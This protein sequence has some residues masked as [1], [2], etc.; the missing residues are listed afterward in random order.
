MESKDKEI[1]SHK[2]AGNGHLVFM[3]EEN[4]FGWVAEML[5]HERDSSNLMSQ[6]TIHY[7]DL[8]H[9]SI[10]AQVLHIV[11]QAD[12]DPHLIISFIVLNNN[13]DGDV[14]SPRGTKGTPS[15]NI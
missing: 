10:L 13:A 14:Y 8:L 3:A 9:N 1:R 7:K 12:W 4:V 11:N 2:F 5:M 6:G 15:N